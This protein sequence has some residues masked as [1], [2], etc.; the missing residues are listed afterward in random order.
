MCWFFWRE[1]KRRTWRKTLGPRTRPR[2]NSTYIH[3]W[4][5]G[6]VWFCSREPVHKSRYRRPNN[7]QQTHKHTMTPKQRRTMVIPLC[8]GTQR[9]RQ[10]RVYD[11]H[12]AYCYVKLRLAASCRRKRYSVLSYNMSFLVSVQSSNYLKTWTSREIFGYFLNHFRLYS[13]DS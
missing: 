5:R 9:L 11:L 7:T 6:L 4:S 3:V 12:K 2:T 8:T 13:L 1:E 10:N